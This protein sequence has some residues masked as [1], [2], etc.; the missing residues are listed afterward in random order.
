[1]VFTLWLDQMAIILVVIILEA[2]VVVIILEIH[3]EAVVVTVTIRDR[4]DFVDQHRREMNIHRREMKCARFLE[5]RKTLFL[6]KKKRF[7]RF[8]LGK[9]MKKKHKPRHQIHFCN[10]RPLLHLSNSSQ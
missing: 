8:V 7:L 10:T 5:R 4:S 1:M 2:V 9:L 3:L 6:K